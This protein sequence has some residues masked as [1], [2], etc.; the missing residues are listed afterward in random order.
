MNLLTTIVYNHIDCIYVTA[1]K[2]FEAF[3]YCIQSKNF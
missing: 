3:K 1:G 2:V